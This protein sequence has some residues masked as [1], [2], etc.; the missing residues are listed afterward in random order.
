MNETINIICRR[1][2]FKV[3][4]VPYSEYEACKFPTENKSSET[5]F[6]NK[7]K[8]FLHNYLKHKIKIEFKKLTYL[9]TH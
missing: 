2:K 7:K 1:I 8:R 6:V 5:S 4:L 3:K 9:N